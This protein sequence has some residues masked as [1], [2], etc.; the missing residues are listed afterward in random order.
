LPPTLPAESRYEI[1]GQVVERCKRLVMEWQAYCA[2][3][4]A[5]RKVFISVKGFYYQ[6][7]RVG[8]GRGVQGSN[9]EGVC[10]Q[11]RIRSAVVN[12]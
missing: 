7:M 5:L 4:N 2:K 9:Q 11:R 6:V 3:C 8:K 12:S 10:V 1:S